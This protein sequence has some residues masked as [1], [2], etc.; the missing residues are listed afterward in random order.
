MAGTKRQNVTHLA[1]RTDFGRRLKRA[2]TAVRPRPT[3]FERLQYL[4]DVNVGVLDVRVRDAQI[5]V[6]QRTAPLHINSLHDIHLRTIWNPAIPDQ[7][8]TNVRHHNRPT[9]RCHHHHHHHHHCIRA[10]YLTISSRW[11][12]CMHRSDLSVFWTILFVIYPGPS[13]HQIPG[14]CLVKNACTR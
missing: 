13:L 8:S 11:I 6:G 12:F 9:S 1:S 7:T 3:T 5:S 4:C 2:A 10:L 14:F